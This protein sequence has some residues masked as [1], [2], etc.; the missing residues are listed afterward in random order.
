MFGIKLAVWRTLLKVLDNDKG[1]LDLKNTQLLCS[2][3]TKATW[4]IKYKNFKTKQFNL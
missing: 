4:Q 1:Q 2:F 3:L